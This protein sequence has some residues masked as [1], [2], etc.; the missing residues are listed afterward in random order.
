MTTINLPPEIDGPLVDEA[1]R[2]GTTPELLAI[3]SLRRLFACAP[4]PGEPGKSDTLLDY[5][6]DYV[7]SIE[8]SEKLPARESGRIFAEAMADKHRRG[9]P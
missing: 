4:A 6:G 2:R 5:L 3:E 8:G 7:A 1:R 9:R